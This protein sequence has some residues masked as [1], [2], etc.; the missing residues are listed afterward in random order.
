MPFAHRERRSNFNMRLKMNSIS[1]ILFFIVAFGLSACAISTHYIQDGARAFPPTDPK[2][3]KI[4]AADTVPQKYEVIGSVAVDNVGD[5]ESAK[6]SLQLEASKMG[7]NAVIR[8]RLSKINS[9][10]SRTGLQGIAVRIMN[11]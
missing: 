1:K 5:A 9:Y 11:L 8:T 3:V 4:Y 7:A 10:A 6:K 2:T